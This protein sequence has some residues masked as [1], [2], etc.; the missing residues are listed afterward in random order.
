MPSQQLTA[1]IDNTNDS[2]QAERLVCHWTT[3]FSDI[4]NN[5]IKISSVSRDECIVSN[6]YMNGT[7]SI[8]VSV[9]C[10]T[11]WSCVKIYKCLKDFQNKHNEDDILTWSACQHQ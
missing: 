3:V 5:L 4:C 8:S 11:P 6:K 10:H 2:I 7:A 1:I 9:P